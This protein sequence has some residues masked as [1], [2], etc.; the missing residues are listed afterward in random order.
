MEIAQ[1]MAYLHHYCFLQV[2]H[3]DLK[4]SNV[5]LGDDMTSYT[6]DFGIS[7]LI[8]SNSAD[9]LTSIDALRGSI[10]YIAPENGIGGNLTTKG[11]VYSYEILI[12]ELLTR[13]RP[14]DD[15]FSEVINL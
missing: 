1:G 7:K 12:L 10:D 11:D 15:M 6:A 14:T 5:L 2:I 3:C 8:F 9:S 13:R 4:P